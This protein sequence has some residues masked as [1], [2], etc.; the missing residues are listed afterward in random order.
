[1]KCLVDYATR[2]PEAVALRNIQL[3]LLRKH[4]FTFSPE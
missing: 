1:M 4:Y 3:R 2:Y